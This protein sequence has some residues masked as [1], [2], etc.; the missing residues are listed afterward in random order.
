[1]S[2]ICAGGGGSTE[3]TFGSGEEPDIAVDSAGTAHVTWQDASRPIDQDVVLYCRIPRGARAC[4]GT[5]MLYTGGIGSVPHVLLPAP[6]QVVVVL[7]D[8]PCADVPWF[9]TRVRVSNNGGA[10]FQAVKTVGV[11]GRPLCRAVRPGHRRPGREHDL[12]GGTTATPTSCSP[13]PR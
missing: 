12:L 1:M 2:D 9:C 4:T 7:G 13:M 3:F 10:T 5:Q 8:E 6:G 11:P